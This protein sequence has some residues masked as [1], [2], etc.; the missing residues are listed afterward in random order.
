VEF[1]WY[2]AT[3]M[4]PTDRFLQWS[5]A[6]YSDCERVEGK[7]HNHYDRRADYLREGLLMLSVSYGGPNGFPNAKATSNAAPRFAE[8]V[9]KDFQLAGQIRVT[10]VDACQDFEAPGAFDQAHSAMKQ[11]SKDRNIL[12]DLDGDWDRAERGRSYYLGSKDSAFR[13]ILY[14]KGIESAAEI[15]AA[16]LPPRPDLCRLEGRL[17]PQ[18]TPAK[19]AASTLT[20]GQIFGCSRWGPA[21]VQ[22]LFSLDV[23]RI[24]MTEYRVP[25]TV[26]SRRALSKQYF[27]TIGDMIAESD[28]DETVLGKMFMDLHDS[29][30]RER[31]Q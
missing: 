9:R 14:E 22:A 7:G 19:V 15:A 23:E 2:Q 24:W 10:R 16:G 18:H 28:H 11:L 21:L 12:T 8:V 1:D 31:S 27:K 4:E 6:A 3:V 5:D 20:P 25:D 30:K 26:L 13:A 29:I 17:K